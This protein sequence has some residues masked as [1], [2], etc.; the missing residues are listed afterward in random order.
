MGLITYI[1]FCLLLSETVVANHTLKLC[2]E[3][4]V[5][6]PIIILSIS[7]VWALLRVSIDVF[8]QIFIPHTE[9]DM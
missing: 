9:K 3:K 4:V 5:V 2:P 7:N 6:F 8:L 1:I